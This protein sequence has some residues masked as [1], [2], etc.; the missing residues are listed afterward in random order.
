MK[1]IPVTSGAT[2]FTPKPAESAGKGFAE[3]LNEKLEEINSLQQE[4]DM[5]IQK[6][7]TGEVEDLHQVMLA[8]ERASLTVQLAV[9]V[10]NK[11]IE[12]YQEV[13]RMQI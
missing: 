3:L 5:M 1:I 12:A 13:S 6:F 9:Q 10:R 8:V 2:S 7:A 11:V 4:S